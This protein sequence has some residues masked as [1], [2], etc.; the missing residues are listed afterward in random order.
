MDC[1]SLGCSENVDAVRQ[2][3]DASEVR[4]GRLELHSDGKKRLCWDL[5]P[6]SF[7]FAVHHS[8]SSICLICDSSSF[9]PSY[10]VRSNEAL[11]FSTSLKAPRRHIPYGK[12]N[13]DKITQM[14]AFGHRTGRRILWQG[15]EC[16][17]PGEIVFHSPN[18]QRSESAFGCQ[19]TSLTSMNVID[20][21]HNRLGKRDMRP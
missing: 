8:T 5:L 10:F 9:R 19:R 15:I 11:Y 3:L 18:R 6:S 20:L 12:V 17:S 7:V 14:L 21:N 16:I 13:T 2:I 4:H 1:L